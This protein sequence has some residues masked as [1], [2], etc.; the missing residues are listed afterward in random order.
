[1]KKRKKTKYTKDDVENLRNDKPVVYRILNGKRVPVYV[2]SAK[3]GRVK[4][5]IKEHIG[6]ISG[7]TV[8]IEQFSSISDAKKKERNVIK[9]RK[10]KHNKQHT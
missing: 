5:R 1:M 2:G 3:K 6:S 10:P 7:S 4:A 8:V 9:R